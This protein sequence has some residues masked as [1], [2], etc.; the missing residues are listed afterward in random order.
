[1]GLGLVQGTTTPE[2]EYGGGYGVASG[3]RGH[4]CVL[5]LNPR[6]HYME[7]WQKTL[8]TQ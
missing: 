1:M 3:Q 5:G 2:E 8:S 7:P 6:K 4:L